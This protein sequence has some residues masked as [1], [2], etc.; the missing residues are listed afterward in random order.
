MAAMSAVAPVCLRASAPSARKSRAGRMSSRVAAPAALRTSAVTGRRAQGMSVRADAMKDAMDKYNEITYKIPPIVTAAAVPVVAVS[1]LAK[2]LTGHGLPGTLLGSIEGVSWLVL[3]LGLGSLAPRLGDVGKAGDF[4]EVVKILTQEGRAYS[5]FGEDSRGKNATERL[6]SITESVDPNSP[7]GQQM[8]D[9]AKRKAALDAETP[10]QKAAR[11]KL[12]AEL[13]AE[14]LGLG[15][16][17]SSDS[18][19]E[20]DE[21]GRDGLLAKPVTQTLK[22]SMTVENYDVDVTKY[23]DKALGGKLNLS[24]P[25]VEN[26]GVPKNN[27]G[28]KWREQYRTEEN[29]AGKA[30]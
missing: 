26:V 30:Q 7:L 6:A 1:L 19:A 20:A 17:I 28:D 8:A 9:I 13:A 27:K 15:K 21:K 18:E 22:E 29:E 16:S 23:D 12:R 3:P 4:G 2:T 5:G 11:E 14:A 24:S 10:E 25:D